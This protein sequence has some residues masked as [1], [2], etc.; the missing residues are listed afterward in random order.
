[1]NSKNLVP[2]RVIPEC[3]ENGEYKNKQCFGE[4]TKGPSFCSCWAPNGDIIT[5]PS[6]TLKSCKCHVSSHL[7]MKNR[8]KF[9]TLNSTLV[10]VRFSKL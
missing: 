7:A 1:M 8:G 6:R 4:A 3:D 5:S 9:V 10:F 2:G